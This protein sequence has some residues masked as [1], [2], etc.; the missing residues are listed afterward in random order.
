VAGCPR[1]AGNS[2]VKEHHERC[3]STTS[4]Q[5]VM[6]KQAQR[7]SIL[8][9]HSQLVHV[10]HYSL[11]WKKKAHREFFEVLFW[12]KMYPFSSPQCIL[13]IL[14]VLSWTAFSCTQ[15]LVLLNCL[16]G[17]S[18]SMGI[19]H[20]RAHDPAKNLFQEHLSFLHICCVSH[21]YSPGLLRQ[22][23][24]PVLMFG[25]WCHKVFAYSPL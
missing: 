12:Y 25:E 17:Q 16:I 21:W 20:P 7:V 2:S 1:I 13:M 10:F 18:H 8:F 6:Y 9:C 4:K 14:R 22:W 15:S 5:P 11:W 23:K 3:A 24:V 19:K